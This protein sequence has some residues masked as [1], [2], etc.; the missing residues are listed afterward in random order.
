M[1]YL[2]N[3]LV[4]PKKFFYLSRMVTPWLTALFLLAFSYGIIGGLILAPADYLQGDGFRILYIHAPCAFLS[5]FIY[6]VM[7]AAA[8]AAIVWR[9]KLAFLVIRHSAPIGAGFTFL[10]LVTGSLWGKPMWGTWWIWD[11][12]LTSEL[13][14]LFLYLGIMLLQ[15]ALAQKRSRERSV[16]I[17]VLAGFVDIPIIHYSVY[18]WNTL[19][20]GATIKVFSPSSIDSSMLSPLLAMIA[21]FLIYYAIV[22]FLRMGYELTAL[23]SNHH[24]LKEQRS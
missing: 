15:S 22:L 21:A 17:L 9:L 23:E 12:R 10:S 18:W 5:L 4:S 8:V 2:F 7:A 16:A 19:H 20:Q 6:A 3:S 24:W 11:A 13:I 14:L 1:W